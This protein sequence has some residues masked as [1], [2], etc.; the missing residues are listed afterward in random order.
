M[1]RA[2]H[3]ARDG[4]KPVHGRILYG[5]HVLRL[6]PGA[7]LSGCGLQERFQRQ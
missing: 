6:D 2:L 1:S 5:M 7:A 4:F 3:D